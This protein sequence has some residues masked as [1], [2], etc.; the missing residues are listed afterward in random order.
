MAIF[1]SLHDAILILPPKTG[2]KWVRQ[3][4]EASQVLHKVDQPSGWRDH[5]PLSVYGRKHK[6]IGT[7]VRDPVEWY[8]S[9]YAYRTQQGWNNRALIDQTCQSSNFTDFVRTAVTHLPGILGIMFE[10]Y[11]GPESDPVTFIGHQENLSADLAMALDKAGVQIPGSW[12][13][14]GRINTSSNRPECS[15]ELEDLIV[16]SELEAMMRYSYFESRPDRT[17]IGTLVKRFPSH[18][19]PLQRLALWTE[20]IH[21]KPDSERVANGRPPRAPGTRYTRLK[22]NFALYAWHVLG[23]LELTWNYF[24]EALAHDGDHPRTLG[25]AALFKHLVANDYSAAESLFQRALDVRPEHAYNL[26]N[27]AHFLHIRYGKTEDANHLF[28]RAL[29]LDPNN[30]RLRANYAAC[31]GNTPGMHDNARTIFLETLSLEPDSPETWTLYGELCERRGDA[32]E[33]KRAFQKALATSQAQEYIEFP[34][35]S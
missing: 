12:H 22:G 16:I 11:T 13:K 2:S 21:W 1:F 23:E 31:L 19:Q 3:A 15:E 28:E 26:G 8:K 9:Y 14:V 32:P 10:T 6:F 20:A 35:S 30:T 7:F 4:L 33:A 18:R 25:N 24:Q 29:A 5:G 27:Y 17:G 34:T